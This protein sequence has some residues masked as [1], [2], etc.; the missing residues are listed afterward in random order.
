MKTRLAALAGFV[1]ALL[2]AGTALAVKP[3]EML[4]DPKLEARARLLSEE[5]RCMV[6]QN[7]SIDESDAELAGDLRVLL[8]ERLL[9]GDSDEQVMAY[10]VSRYGEFVLLKPQFNLRN[11]LLWGTPVLLLLGG[12]AFVVLQARS[13]RRQEPAGL[14]KDEQ[15]ALDAIL[16][17]DA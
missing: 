17:K 16:N 13:R 6:C 3:S 11:A 2:F 10:I 7:Q 8:R 5:L 15:A 1:A 12:G 14:T 9:A 4:A